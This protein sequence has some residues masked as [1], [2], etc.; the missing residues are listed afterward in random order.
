[1]PSFR[2]ADVR[3]N[4]C[5]GGYARAPVTKARC[6]R[7]ENAQAFRRF[8][9]NASRL[10][11][12]TQEALKAKRT[13]AA[14][15]KAGSLRFRSNVRQQLVRVEAR[16]LFVRSTD[17]GKGFRVARNARFRGADDK[18]TRSVGDEGW[19]RRQGRTPLRRRGQNSSPTALARFLVGRAF[20]VK[21]D[22]RRKKLVHHYR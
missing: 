21:K 19:T 17:G 5:L 3:A 20:V 2:A 16:S 4:P 11:S 10:F 8:H 7:H 9:E 14:G 18:G 15:V 6:A 12:I 1:M 22:A 13:S